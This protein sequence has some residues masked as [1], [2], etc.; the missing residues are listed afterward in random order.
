MM[1]PLSPQLNNFNTTVSSFFLLKDLSVNELGYFSGFKTISKYETF[2]FPHPHEFRSSCS[3]S[4]LI[5]TNKKLIKFCFR[6]HT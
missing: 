1:L 2:F 3:L 5:I 6:V 4:Y